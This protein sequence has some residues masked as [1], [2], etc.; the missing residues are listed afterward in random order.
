MSGGYTSLESSIRTCKVNA[1]SAEKIESDRF[2][3]CADQKT[4]PPFLG[5]DMIGRAI[6]PDSFQTKSPGCNTIQDRLFIENNVSRPQYYNYITLSSNGLN[7]DS[8][9]GF[10]LQES[11]YIKDTGGN[12]CCGLTAIP[13]VTYDCP[14]ANTVNYT[15][16][17]PDLRFNPSELTLTD[18]PICATPRLNSCGE[19]SQPYSQMYGQHA[20]QSR[21]KQALLT[22]AQ[23][24]NQNAN[25]PISAA[26]DTAYLTNYG[27]KMLGNY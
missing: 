25:A 22:R 9:F 21:L 6:C 4:C 27:Y 11:S 14:I 23:I 2:L 1:S 8:G 15:D 18:A 10:G 13:Q 3:G 12:N 17:P 26:N 20:E 19:S 16:L 24:V 7:G 5:T